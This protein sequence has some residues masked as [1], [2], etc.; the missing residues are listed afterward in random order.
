MGSAW[1]AHGR[2]MGSSAVTSLHAHTPAV[3]QLRSV[4]VR[5]ASG[6]GCLMLVVASHPDNDDH[7]Q[8]KLREIAQP[9]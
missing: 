8:Q 5:S 2:R 7:E 1:A 3:S 4:N 9:I 6:S